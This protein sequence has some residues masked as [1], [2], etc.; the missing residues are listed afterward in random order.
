MERFKQIILITGTPSVGKTAVSSLLASKLDALHVDLGDLVKQEMLWNDVDKRRGTL[1]ANISKLSRRVQSLIESSR[2]DVVLD[3]HYAV[4]V[5]PARSVSKV[6]VLRREPDELRQMMLKRGFKGKKLK[7]NLAAEVL[8]VCLYN[9][10]KACGVDRV[11]EINVTGKKTEEV[12]EEIFAVL[13]R[14]K[15]CV[16]G[17]V[18][19]L[20]KLENENR[21]EEFLE[22]F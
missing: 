15:A 3:G 4:D 5:V 8:D 19:W 1:I 9:A 2:G 11:C 13:E 12:V 17:R 10:V 21:V 22:D 18:D 20:G 16:V 14:K 7:E 6:F